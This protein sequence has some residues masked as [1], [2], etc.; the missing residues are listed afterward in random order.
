MTKNIVTLSDG[1][2]LIFTRDRG[3]LV[4]VQYVAA[5]VAHYYTEA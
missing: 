4:R 1:G 3:R 5:S 2:L